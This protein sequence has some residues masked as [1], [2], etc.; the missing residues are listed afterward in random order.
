VETYNL[1]P[2]LVAI[3]ARQ[4]LEEFGARGDIKG[5]QDDSLQQSVDG[6]SVLA[7]RNYVH[8][9]PSPPDWH[10]DS[11]MLKRPHSQIDHDPSTQAAQDT[12]NRP[13]KRKPDP[14]SDT[15]GSD[16]DD[17]DE[18]E[19]NSEDEEDENIPLMFC[20]YDKVSRTKN[21]WRAN[22]TSGVLCIEGKEWVFEKGSGE[23]EW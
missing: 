5:N 16:L 1:N 22:M 14:N 17:S 10:Q 6:L 23:F 21:R 9:S 2:A 18:A 19:M 13:E 8:E 12:F 11:N 15:I 3:R 4:H 7:S 20:L